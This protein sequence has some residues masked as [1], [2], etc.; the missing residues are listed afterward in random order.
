MLTSLCFQNLLFGNII[1]NLFLSWNWCKSK[2]WNKTRSVRVILTA[3]SCSNR[4]SVAVVLLLRF[5]GLPCFQVFVTCPSELNPI[6]QKKN[7]NKP[8]SIV[9][10]DADWVL[11][12][13]WMD[14]V[15]QDLSMDCSNVLQSQA[16]YEKDKYFKLIILRSRVITRKEWSKCKICIQL[17]KLHI[18]FIV[19]QLYY[20]VGVLLFLLIKLK[21]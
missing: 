10:L 11:L 1:S 21:L 2:K 16:K 17:M 6:L 19:L 18:Y 12:D 9:L 20:W 8:V 15:H 13:I 7:R 14:K 3:V 5:G 4:N